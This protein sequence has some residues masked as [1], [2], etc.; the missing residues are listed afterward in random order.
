MK[1]SRQESWSGLLF[2]SSGDLSDPG[3]KP[4]S[5]ILLADSLPSQPPGK[6]GWHRGKEPTCQCR[7]RKRREFNPWV[8][9]WQPTPI[10]LPG[11][12][13]GQR[14]RAGYSPW[15]RKGLEVTE[16]SHTH[17]RIQWRSLT[18]TARPG[19]Q[20]NI[21]GSVMLSHVP[22]WDEMRD[23]HLCGLPPQTHDSEKNIRLNLIGRHP[24]KPLPGPP[25]N[26]HGHQKQG[27][28]EKL[29]LPEELRRQDD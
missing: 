6:H 3:I 15:G 27:K 20:V 12:F 18:G 9:K 28:P 22:W 10:F 24:T 13:H 21:T 5:P 29:S 26:Q 1:F 25:Q 23:L 2:P 14:S 8:R 7:K 19:D 4:R 17:V 11:E 16:Q